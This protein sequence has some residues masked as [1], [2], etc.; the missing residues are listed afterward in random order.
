MFLSEK[1]LLIKRLAM[2]KYIMVQE[3]VE[4]VIVCIIV[5]LKLIKFQHQFFNSLCTA[6]LVIPVSIQNRSQID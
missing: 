2:N 5:E 1:T 3:F 6:Q 4:A